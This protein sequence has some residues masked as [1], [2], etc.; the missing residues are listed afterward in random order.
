MCE[1][2]CAG[3]MGFKEFSVFNDSLLGRQAWRLVNGENTLFG[4]V[5]KAKYYPHSTFLEAYLGYSTSHSW[6]GI[7]SNKAQVK[8]G[9]IWLV[10]NGSSADVWKDPWVADEEGGFITSET[11]DC[12][13]NVSD[14]IDLNTMEWNYE[15]IMSSFNVRDQR[16]ILD[17]PLSLR[18]PTYIMTWAYS[19]DGNYYVKTAY[20]LR[21]GCNFDAIHLAWVEIWGLD[22][23]PKLRHFFWRLCTGTLPT[24]SLL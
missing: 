18:A 6:R 5:M 13:G 23:S 17:I 7:W 9:V 19:N 24:R 10:G 3:G 11:I 20:M 14:L 15:L 21:K 12:I 22:A 16:C 4:K 1:P 2:K 8:E